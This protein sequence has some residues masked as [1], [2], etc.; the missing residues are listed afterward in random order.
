MINAQNTFS[1]SRKD[2]RTKNNLFNSCESNSSLSQYSEH[3]ASGKN[4]M[5]DMAL[6]PWQPHDQMAEEGFWDKKE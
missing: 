5:I 6:A 3:D 2:E 4:K 1:R